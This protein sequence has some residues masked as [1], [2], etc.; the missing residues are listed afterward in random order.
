MIPRV[1]GFIY[2]SVTR[3]TR[4]SPAARFGGTASLQEILFSPVW[5]DEVAPHRRKR[6]FSGAARRPKP[7]PRNSCL[8]GLTQSACSLRQ[9]STF[10]LLWSI[11]ARP[12]ET[13]PQG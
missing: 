12:G 5:G 9:R 2:S 4:S 7:P 10:F 3:V 6:R 1:I 13:A 11:F 8:L